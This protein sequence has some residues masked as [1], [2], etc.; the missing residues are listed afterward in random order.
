MIIEL[1]VLFPQGGPNSARRIPIATCI[2][3]K[4]PAMQLRALHEIAFSPTSKSPVQ[5]GYTS[6]R[7]WAI[8]HGEV[9]NSSDTAI[10]SQLTALGK[11]K[12]GTTAVSLIT[13]PSAIKVMRALGHRPAVVQAMVALQQAAQAHVPGQDM[14]GGSGRSAGGSAAQIPPLFTPTHTMPPICIPGASPMD[15]PRHGNTA[16]EAGGSRVDSQGEHA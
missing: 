5:R 13:L 15:T 9:F 6:F 3:G 7:E 8:R 14:Q 12:A 10:I 1:D 11:I 2:E 16:L 4:Q